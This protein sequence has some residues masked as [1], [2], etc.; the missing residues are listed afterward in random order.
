MFNFLFKTNTI[1]NTT[2]NNMLI[3]ALSTYLIQKG[4]FPSET[5]MMVGFKNM[6]ATSYNGKKLSETQINSI[7]SCAFALK[8]GTLKDELREKLIKLSDGMKKQNPVGYEEVISILS[9]N[10]IIF[11]EF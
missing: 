3:V 11:S 2:F 5:E 6:I 9:S 1:D 10:G 8:I 7:K 4:E